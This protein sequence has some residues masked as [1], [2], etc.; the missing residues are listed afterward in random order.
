MFVNVFPTSR[1]GGNTR[2]H[3]K[4]VFLLVWYCFIVSFNFKLVVCMY[5]CVLLKLYTGFDELL[6]VFHLALL[7]NLFMKW[8]LL[9]I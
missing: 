4:F 1:F 9:M 7:L 5:M 3:L 6:K 2:F 8:S